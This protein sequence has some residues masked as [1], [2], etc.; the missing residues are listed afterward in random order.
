ML[1]Y[2]A[3][4]LCH[5]DCWAQ[6][7]ANSLTG[8]AS[9]ATAFAIL[10]SPRQASAQAARGSLFLPLILL[11]LAGALPGVALLLHY[12]G[13]QLV[14]AKLDT[15]PGGMFPSSIFLF[16]ALTWVAPLL[17]PVLALA[18]AWLL[19]YYMGFFLDARTSRSEL[20]RL[21]AW[22]L[23][24]LAI[25][26]VLAG[27]LIVFC[28]EECDLFNPLASNVAFFL[29]SQETEVFTYE[30]ARGLDVF[31]VWAVVITGRAIAARYERSVGAVAAGIAALFLLAVAARAW[32]LG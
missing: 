10:W 27:M 24:P 5:L 18:A 15:T 4:V 8:N 1:S 20:R 31:S 13:P 30:L 22:G 23:L 12:G 26:R 29:Q 21:V 14:Q 2:I 17:W 11:A 32:L 19:D 25:E 9:V 28:G 7:Q 6:Y 16:V 3:A